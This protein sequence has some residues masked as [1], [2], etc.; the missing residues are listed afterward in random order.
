MPLVTTKLGFLVTTSAQLWAALAP[1]KKRNIVYPKVIDHG[2]N[3][4]NGLNEFLE[5]NEFI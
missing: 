1:K 4:L 3:E 2:L 5:F